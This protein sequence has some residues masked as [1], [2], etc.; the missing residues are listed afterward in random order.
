MA[1]LSARWIGL[2]LALIIFR[3]P[4]LDARSGGGAITGGE[5]G[6]AKSPV[7]GVF[8]CGFDPRGAE[9]QIHT[10]RLNLLRSN[11]RR[12]A[13]DGARQPTTLS[14]GPR[15]ENIDNVALIEDDGTIVVQP[16]KF[17]LK[18][19]SL[20]FT[21]DGAGYRIERGAPSFETDRGSK[22]PG[23]LGADGKPGTGNNG[24]SN[25]S[26]AG[27]LFPFYGN[28]YDTI[29]V[30]TNGY[31]TFV[32]GDTSA[33][34]SAASLASEMP[35]IAP[36]WADLDVHDGGNIYYNRLDGRH[37]VT[38]D[39]VSE[40]VYGGKSTFQVIL[41]DDGRIAFVYKKVKARSS[42]TGISPGNSALDPHPIDFTDP[43]GEAVAAP[44]FETFSNQKRLD[45]PALT[46]ALYRTQPDAFDVVFIWTDFAFD[47]GIGVAHSFNIRNDIGGIG[48][49]IFD[50]GSQYGSPSRLDT[51]ITMGNEISW[52]SN[53]EALT[54]G[55]NTA[56]CIVCHELGHRWLTYIHFDDGNVTKDDLLGRDAS[57]WSFL[58][59][60][61]T[62]SQG[63]FSSLMEGNAWRDSGSGTF[64]TIESAVNHFSPLD[65]YL[66]GLRAADE[67]GDIRY[68]VTDAAFTQLIREKSPVSGLS[69]SAVRKTT[70]VSQ[71]IAHEGL[72]VPDVSSAPKELRAAFLLVNQQ[73]SA[74]SASSI[75][76]IARYRDALVRYFGA[77]TGRRAS[78]DASL[79]Q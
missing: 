1:A 75:E 74:P 57:H 6:T 5:T 54:A 24:Y 42:L 27:A 33:R 56:V 69:L 21:P 55:L 79:V 10:H 39:S 41:Y 9:D 52:P 68:L 20:I 45:L 47:N 50:R 62:N 40:V 19:R 63:S 66:M 71:I 25:V 51:V 44:F 31:I 23:F 18:K 2:A 7:G 32:Q 34:I 60:S 28:F 53:P 48:L 76:K 49:R 77:A 8:D 67:V 65:Q 70:S 13:T 30:G 64:T 46:R 72:R 17:N 38:W 14:L 61:R 37:L 78:L 58:V 43:P 15:A 36:L 3:P 4:L 11:A 26:L 73:G 12:A 22:L 59:D 29:Y 35:R 16:N